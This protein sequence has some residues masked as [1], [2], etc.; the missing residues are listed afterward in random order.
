MSNDKNERGFFGI[1]IPEEILN[2]KELTITEKYIFGY[3]ASFKKC[4][5]Q[6]NEAIAEKL[7]VSKSSVAHTL[8]NLEARGFLFVEK[9]N[10]NNGMRRIYSIL[11]NPKKIA[12][13]QKIGKLKPCGKPVEKSGG[14]VQNMHKLVQNL[15]EDV[16]NLHYDESKKT[17]VSSAKYAHIE[18]SKKKNKVK[19]G[20][21]SAIGL[22]QNGQPIAQNGS[23]SRKL[24]REDFSNENDF[25]KAFY[26]R[27]SKR[28]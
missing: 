27:N 25:E 17:G 22:A 26:N 13:L 1:I 9:V 23:S 2:D 28:L 15:H 18:E 4:C 19:V 10:G 5:F 7:G 16:Q 3:I 6:S 21:N 14:V 20:Q 8:P 12:Y 24:K 11:E